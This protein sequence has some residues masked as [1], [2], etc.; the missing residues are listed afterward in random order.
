MSAGPAHPPTTPDDPGDTAVAA[1][2]QLVREIDRCA[3]ELQDA[4][5]RAQ[6]LLTQR[7]SGDSWLDIVTGEARPLVVER[8]ST[9]LST[10]AG[11]GSSWR[12]AQAR[13]LQAEQVS[14][15]RIAAMFGVTRQRISALLRDAPGSSTGTLEDPPA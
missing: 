9:V 1:L 11:A 3:V 15:N 8:I 4:R 6:Q 5:E 12:R 2:E 7:R 13:A 10:L 14:I